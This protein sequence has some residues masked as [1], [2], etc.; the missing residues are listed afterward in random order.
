MGELCTRTLNRI[1]R[2]LNR[3]N[4]MWEYPTKTFQTKRGREWLAKVELSPMDRLEM[5][6]LLEQWR[7]WEDQIARLEQEIVVRAQQHSPEQIMSDVEL[8]AT[9]PGVSHYSGLALISR[10]GPIDR[11]PRPRSLAN[12]FGV[13]PG[14]RNSGNHQ[15]RLGSIT[16]EG[17]GIVR[18]HLGQIVIH[19][20]KKDRVI[21]EWY[22]KIK[23]RRGSKIARVA[24]MRRICTIVW[25]MLTHRQAYTVGGPI[26][27]R[28][29]ECPTAGKRT[30]DSVTAEVFRIGPKAKGPEKPLKGERSRAARTLALAF[31]SGTGGRSGCSSAEPYPPTGQ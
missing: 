5:D 16:K 18:F 17:S 31:A 4:L 13:T 1:R 10:I 30:K 6:L 14:C 2:I 19:V 28:S 11:F 8:L 24:V 15:H 25:H 22:R 3:H 12:F 9:I 21:R 23:A 27:R 20:L 26:R 7:L 29:A